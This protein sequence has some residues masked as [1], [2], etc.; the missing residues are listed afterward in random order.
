MLSYKT[1]IQTKPRS[2]SLNC[3]EKRRLTTLPITLQPTATPENNLPYHT[4][5]PVL[6][7]KEKFKSNTIC[8][9]IPFITKLR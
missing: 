7:K 6:I 5:T 8:I 9:Q 2:L 3:T 4:T 1:K